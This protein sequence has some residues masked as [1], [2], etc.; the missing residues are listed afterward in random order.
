[1]STIY[2]GRL[3]ESNLLSVELD[4][5]NDQCGKLNR[6]MFVIKH[7]AKG[8]LIDSNNIEKVYNSVLSKR[9]KKNK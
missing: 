5:L 7:S 3:I 6:E 4:T 2:P 1:M 8:T 9:L